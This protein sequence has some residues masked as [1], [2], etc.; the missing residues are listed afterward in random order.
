MKYPSDRTKAAE[1]KSLRRNYFVDLRFRPSVEVLRERD[2]RLA[3]PRSLTA[4]IMG[5]PP[6]GYSALDKR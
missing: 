2:I 6:P 4:S 5:D 3:Q 1:R